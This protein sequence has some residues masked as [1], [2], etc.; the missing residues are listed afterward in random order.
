M[1]RFPRIVPTS[2]RRLAC[3][4]A[5]TLAVG[6]SAVSVGDAGAAT[7]HHTA[8]LVSTKQSTTLG[9]YLVTTSGFTLYTFKLDTATI[10]RVHRRLR[11]RVA[12]AARAQGR[13]A[14]Q[15]RARDQVL[16]AGQGEPGP[17]EVPTHLPGQAP[18][19][20]LWG[21]VGGPDRWRRIRERLVRRDADPEG[22]AHRDTRDRHGAADHCGGVARL[23]ELA[24]LVVPT[25]LSC[26]DHAARDHAAGDHAARDHAARDHAADTRPDPGTHA[27]ANPRPDPDAADRRV[28]LLRVHGSI[29]R[30]I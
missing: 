30:A 3:A 2:L 27:C 15:P 18:L 19:S 6:T 13:Q 20:L 24:Q 25:E 17:R 26:A 23:V 16:E 9:T 5:L 21:Q 22:G 28:R 29:T 4:T 7:K 14:L 8:V 1:P 12:P 11:H 10:E